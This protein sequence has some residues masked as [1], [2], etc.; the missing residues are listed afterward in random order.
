M[1]VYRVHNLSHLFCSFL[2]NH[3]ETLI[4]LV[5]L[6]A[7]RHCKASNDEEYEDNLSNTTR[8]LPAGSLSPGARLEFFQL[9]DTDLAKDSI[10]WLPG[11]KGE[12]FAMNKQKFEKILKHHFQQKCDFA[13]FTRQLS[14]WYVIM[15]TQA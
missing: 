12:A 6:S 7:K 10:W 9:L 4:S 13:E 14:L 11:R 8:N 3:H 5:S 1:I 15:C 2:K